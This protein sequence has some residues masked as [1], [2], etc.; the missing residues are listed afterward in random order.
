MIYLDNA[1]TSFPKNESAIRNAVDQYLSL[2]ASPGR[3]GYDK[4][5]E[6]G[7]LVTKVR[8]K[9]LD[10][11]DAPQGSMVCFASNA[12]DA[13]NTLIQG[14]AEPG[15]HFLSTR[16]EH[17]SVLRPL[18]YMVARGAEFNLIDFDKDGYLSVD[19]IKKGLR[20]QTEA[21]IVTHASNVLGTVQP[22]TDIGLE[23]KKHGAFFCVDASQSA[24][25]IPISMRRSNISALAFT[26]HKSIKGPTGIGGLVFTPDLNLKP[27]RFG[28]SGVDSA[29]S[30]QPDEYP[31]RLEAGT[32]NMLGLLALYNCLTD[33]DELAMNNDLKYEMDLLQRLYK[34]LSSL[35]QVEIYGCSD[36]DRKVPV[37][38]CNIKNLT[39]SDTGAILDGD[40]GIAVRTGLHCS[41][42][43]H[44]VLGTYP[45]GM[46]RFSIGPA[47]SVADIDAA[48]AAFREICSN[49]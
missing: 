17:N 15:T 34:G 4:A 40:F 26:G 48:I 23:I 9:I 29:N 43:V 18:H 20:A 16:L 22:I 25:V 13:L 39:A 36:F 30:F 7:E 46:V 41:P 44:K 6:A 1:A 33:L 49:L 27:S 10:F 8:Q 19:K 11:F 21:V 32:Q 14:L 28:G 3:G 35:P 45:D 5:V 47:N 12:T 2:G 24:G 38:S 37:L 31:V 42:L